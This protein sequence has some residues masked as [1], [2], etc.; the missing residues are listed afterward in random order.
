MTNSSPGKDLIL[1]A[2]ETL[3]AS[4]GKTATHRA[5]FLAE[6]QKGLRMQL[7]WWRWRRGQE[8]PS[9][10]LL[11]AF[12]TSVQSVTSHQATQRTKQESPNVTADPKTPEEWLRQKQANT[13][14]LSPT[15]LLS[16]STNTHGSREDRPRLPKDRSQIPWITPSCLF[17][18]QNP[19]C[20]LKQ[21]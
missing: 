8:G 2:F 5:P 4:P 14:N 11:K 12:L 21:H 1:C 16:D 18:T 7:L 3:L 17:R 15:S 6:S 10:N 9:F 19:K 20:S 13:H